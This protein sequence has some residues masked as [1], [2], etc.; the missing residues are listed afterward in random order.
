MKKSYWLYLIAIIIVAGFSGKIFYGMYKQY[1]NQIAVEKLESDKMAKA[2]REIAEVRAHAKK[3]PVIELPYCVNYNITDM[4]S[5]PEPMLRDA[6][7]VCFSS[8]MKN[9]DYKTLDLMISSF[10][11]NKLRTPAGLW[12]QSV[13]Y[14]SAKR[15]PD[16]ALQEK[17][18]DR[19]DAELNDWMTKSQKSDAAKLILVD[20]MLKRAWLYRGS[21]FSNT[22]S[23]V[24]FSKFHAQISK[25]KKYLLANE[26]ISLRDPKWFSQIL[27]VINLEENA[28]SLE[29]KQYFDN[30]ISLYPG[31][32]PIYLS[33]SV[34]YYE[35]WHGT[36]I[37]SFD[38]FLRYA[39]K[40]LPPNEA[41][42]VYTKYIWVVFVVN[43]MMTTPETGLSIGRKLQ[44]ASTR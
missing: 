29:H 2:A 43:A 4:N 7:S 16:F 6:V 38:Q 20:S 3:R 33:A 11:D 31:Y 12:L 1:Q 23:P 19:I 25:A 21:G 34:F 36:G 41:K 40:N 26:D 14:Q 9:K 35:K 22:V 28:S 5:A 42:A 44:Q 24:N 17:D 27:E 30:A 10:R 32:N 37:D 39:V 18:F 13:F 15:Y 8:L